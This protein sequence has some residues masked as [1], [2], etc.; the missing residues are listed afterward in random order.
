MREQGL[1]IWKILKQVPDAVG[2]KR[3]TPR[4]HL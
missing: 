4:S 3:G 2:D 1:R